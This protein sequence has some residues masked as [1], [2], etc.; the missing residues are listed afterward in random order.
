MWSLLR[1]RR[2]DA[3][4]HMQSALRASLL[5]LG[6]KAD[7]TLGFDQQ[8]A[9]DGQSLFTNVKVPSP[10]SPHVLDGFMA[11]AAELGIHDLTPR[12]NITSLWCRHKTPPEAAGNQSRQSR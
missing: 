4:L 12:W 6:I 9:G 8:R 11:F 7:K 3:L 1:H 5:T 2:F 10:Q